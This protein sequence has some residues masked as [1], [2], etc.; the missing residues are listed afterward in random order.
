[1]DVIVA[2]LGP[3]VS[4]L[5][6]LRAEITRLAD[7]YELHLQHTERL[8]TRIVQATEADLKDTAVEYTDPEY[9]EVIASIEH[10]AGRSVTDDEARQIMQL[11]TEDKEG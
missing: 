11:L 2:R 8:T 7:L 6:L 10:R 3:L 1:M 4:E 9:A 5:R